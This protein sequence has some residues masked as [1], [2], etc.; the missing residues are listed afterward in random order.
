MELDVQLKQADGSWKT[1]Y[2]K[3]FTTGQ[4]WKN[5]TNNNIVVGQAGQ[6]FR[7][8][9]KAVSTATRSLS[10][11]NF[12][13]NLAFGLLQFEDPGEN[14][15]PDP[16][17]TQDNP[18][19][20][21]V[22]DNSP[23]KPISPQ[24]ALEVL[25]TSIGA[26]LSPETAVSG[27]MPRNT[28]AAPAGLQRLLSTAAIAVLQTVPQQ[29]P[30]CKAK[31][32]NPKAKPDEQPESDPAN[33]KKA[34]A[35]NF[36]YAQQPN[37]YYGDRSGFR[38]WFQG[39]AAS[40]TDIGNP[41]GG[42]WANSASTSGGGA[43]FGIDYSITETSQ[44]GVFGSATTMNLSQYGFGGGEWTPTGYG[45][46]LYGRWSPGPWFL[47]GLVQY[48]SFEGD[49]SRGIELGTSSLRARGRKSADTFTAALMTGARINLSPY[50]FITPSANLNW[51]SINENRF[52]ESGGEIPVAN[53]NTGL[54]NLN[55]QAHNTSWADTDLGVSI[56]QAIQNDTTLVIPAARISWFGNWK[57]QGG[58][59]VINYDFSP[60]KVYVPGGWLDRNGLR[61][62]L[63]VDT[64]TRSNTTLF[65]RG[66]V[67]FGQDSSGQGPITDYGVNGGI[68]IRF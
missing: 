41:N 32:N 65:V 48:G 35:N 38:T 4:E 33:C 15:M 22:A 44:L 58:S 52:K 12:I 30:Q 19:N 17:T 8:L 13:D 3:Q 25:S 20:P 62:S 29:V 6:E 66:S 46:G 56:S 23:D 37:N 1:V 53:G 45:V 42:A 47:S 67:D 49:Q 64:I 59:Q 61:L 7:F 55:Y 39:F 27:F 60:Q 34:Q 16:F 28:D 5:Y 10:V 54:F 50:T 11:G 57:T 51:S 36:S 24:K 68:S 2:S 14:I 26:T 40:L 9:F 63:G 21:T 18:S 43:L 31:A